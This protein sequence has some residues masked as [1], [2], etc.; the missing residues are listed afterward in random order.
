[1]VDIGNYGNYQLL[2]HTDPILLIFGLFGVFLFF[3]RKLRMQLTFFL[4]FLLIPFV[5]QSA[6]APLQKHFAFMPL[7]FA[8]PGAYG[9]NEIIEFIKRKN[10][11]KLVTIGLFV[12]LI[13]MMLITLGNAYGTPNNYYSKS[14]VS[15]LKNYINKNVA[16]NDLIVFDS[17]IYTAEN[18]W[19]ATDKHFVDLQQ[20]VELYQIDQTIPVEQ[21]SKL[22]IHVVECVIDDCGWGW[23]AQ[24]QQVNLSSE[25]I[26]EGLKEQ[27]PESKSIE[28]YTYKGNEIFGDKEKTEKFRIYVANSIMSQG[29]IKQTDSLNQFYF[30]P[31]LYKNMNDYVYNYIPIGFDYILHKISLWIIYL[32]IILSVLAVL[33]TASLP[34]SK[35]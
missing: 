28:S 27:I 17:R 24:N 18:F 29:L 3:K 14:E 13:G 21:K 11:K 30:V 15:Q 32:S 6:G 8:I 1:M 35:D 2:Y 34:F 25:S 5:L 19:L 7:L 10:G 4:L 9:L 33:K 23:I 31:Y 12:I 20:F 16:D 22:K 26:L